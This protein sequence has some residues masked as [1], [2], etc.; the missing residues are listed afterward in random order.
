MS[1]SH[2]SLICHFV[3]W[4]QAGSLRRC[5]LIKQL[6]WSTTLVELLVIRKEFRL[7]RPNAR[8]RQCYGEASEWAPMD[9]NSGENQNLSPGSKIFGR[10]VLIVA[11]VLTFA[12]WMS[13]LEGEI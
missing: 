5:L 6:R 11:L 7:V 8:L 2:I 10:Q 12:V 4:R 3:T 9:R 13:I 1:P